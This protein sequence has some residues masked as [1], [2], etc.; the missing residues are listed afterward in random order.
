M[1]QDEQFTGIAGAHRDHSRRMECSLESTPSAV[2]TEMGHDGSRRL[3]VR[4]ATAAGPEER[5]GINDND[6]S[7]GISPNNPSYGRPP[8]LSCALVGTLDYWI[9]RTF[10]QK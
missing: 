4:R 5:H 1:A 9:S 7:E 6:N 8:E 10:W 3:Y 2:L